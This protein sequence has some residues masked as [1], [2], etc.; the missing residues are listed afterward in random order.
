MTSLAW[1]LVQL[2]TAAD[3]FPICRRK[4]SSCVDALVELIES[5]ELAEIVPQNGRSVGWQVGAVLNRCMEK[6]RSRAMVWTT[7]LLQ[8]QCTSSRR[9]PDGKSFAESSLQSIEKEFP[10]KDQHKGYWQMLFVLAS[11]V[12]SRRSSSH[13]IPSHVLVFTLRK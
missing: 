1:V 5:S 11:H 3:V 13:Q 12:V 8:S 9:M 4:A 6:L 2:S 10:R 7:V